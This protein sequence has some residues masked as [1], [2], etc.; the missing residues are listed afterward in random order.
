MVKSLTLTSWKYW[1]FVVLLTDNL[2]VSL[3]LLLDAVGH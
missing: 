2:R 3:A 1:F